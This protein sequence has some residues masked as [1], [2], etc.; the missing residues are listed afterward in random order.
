MSDNGTGFCRLPEVTV[1]DEDGYGALI[2]PIMNAVPKSEAKAS[3]VAQQMIF[4]PGGEIMY[5]D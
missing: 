2:Y 1:T 3:P 4:C 5:N